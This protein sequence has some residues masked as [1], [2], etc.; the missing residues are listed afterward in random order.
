MIRSA[1]FSGWL[2]AR[3]ELQQ[4]TMATNRQDGRAMDWFERLTGFAESTGAAGYETTRRG[5]E[6]DG[7]QLRSRVNG[8]SYGIGELE[9]VSLETL[10]Q[11]AR[12]AAPL[13]RR[14]SVSIVVDDVRKLHAAPRNNGALFQVASQFNLLEMIGPEVTPEHGVTIYANDP[15]QGPAC[16][17]AAGAATVY[18]NYFAP[19]GGTIG[20]TKVRQHDGFADLG[21]AVAQ[22]LG[23]PSGSLWTMRNGYAMFTRS[24]LELMSRHVAS[25]D[26]SHRD[27]LRQRLCIG[28]HWDVEVT[29]IAALPGPLVSQ[30]FCSALPVSY[31]DNRTGTRGA[32]WAPLATL[33]LEAAYE[34]TLWAA[35]INA[36]RGASGT[37]LLTMLGGGAF[38]NNPAWIQ[39][40]MQRA[41]EQVKGHGLDVVLVSYGVPSA[42]LQQWAAQMSNLP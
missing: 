30:A 14:S 39:A 28:L 23:K 9:L 3:D 6:V 4:L 40:A 24:G 1:T 33:V 7:R 27:A 32:D 37:V 16:A 26:D 21:A 18:R 5:L 17:I 31:N 35:I 13:G 38:G 2:A 12:L 25:L 19:V 20:Q 29:D 41:I 8:R 36:Q 11:R 15:T 42:A 22:A 34:A 10:R